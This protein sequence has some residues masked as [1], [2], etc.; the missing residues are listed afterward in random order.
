MV[1][2][3]SVDLLV[4]GIAAHWFPATWWTEAERVVKP[5][6]SV[7]LFTYRGDVRA[8][9]ARM[10]LTPRSTSVSQ[11]AQA[12]FL[13]LL[14]VGRAACRALAISR[15]PRLPRDGCVARPSLGLV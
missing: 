10:G 1:E 5:G 11:R 8:A 15:R 14:R 6:G 3:A 2:D 12:G 4:C 7:A 13:S 9:S